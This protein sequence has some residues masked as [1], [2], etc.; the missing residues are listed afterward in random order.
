MGR[1]RK[2]VKTCLE[3]MCRLRQGINIEV[4]FS[5]SMA[6]VKLS[7]FSLKILYCSNERDVAM[8]GGG[9]RVVNFIWDKEHDAL[10]GKIYDH[11]MGRQLQQMLEDLHPKIKKA[12]YVHWKTDEG[13]RYRRLTNRANRVSARSSKYT[14]SSVTFIK[15]K[16]RLSKSLDRDPTLAETF[17]YTQTLKENKERFVDQRSANHY[18][19]KQL[20]L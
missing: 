14:G 6:D 17:K 15:T 2:K 7:W 11:R 8:N 19:R 18:V 10:I 20:I 9:F 1:V 13:F 5:Q 12:L 4:C 3:N 16:A